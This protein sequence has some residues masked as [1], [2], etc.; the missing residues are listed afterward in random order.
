MKKASNVNLYRSE[1]DNEKYPFHTFACFND[2]KYDK[3]K[4]HG[5]GNKINI[6]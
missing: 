3:L 2:K 4:T 6:E 1:N 5:N